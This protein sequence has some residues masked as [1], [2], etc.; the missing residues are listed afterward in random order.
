LGRWV[1]DAARGDDLTAAWA[2][3]DR[4]KLS[5]IDC[6]LLA[7]AQASSCDVFLS[8]DMHH[9]MD[10]DGVIILNP[11]LPAAEPIFDAIGGAA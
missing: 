7:A 5:F 10:I 3:Q 11:F 1:G 2:I 6:L 4:Y 9:G 8:E